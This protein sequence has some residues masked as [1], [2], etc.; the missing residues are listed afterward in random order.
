M[1]KKLPFITGF[2]RISLDNLALVGGKNASLGEMIQSL[3]QSD[4]SVPEGFAITTAAFQYFLDRNDLRQKIADILSE[5]DKSDID[6]FKAS[7]EHIR[8][9][10]LSAF[11]PEEIAREIE[12]AY[13]ALIAISGNAAVAVRSSATAEDLPGLSFAGQHDS[14]LFIENVD[15]LLSACKRCYASLYTDRALSYR[16]D[17]G[18]DHL[19][20]ALSIGVQ[21][22]VQADNA[23]SGVMFTLDPESGSRQSVLVSG[24]YGIGETI[25]QGQVEPDEFYVHKATFAEGFESVHRH[26]LGKKHLKMIRNADTSSASTE[27]V[28]V[29][30]EDQQAF[31]LRDADIIELARAAMAIE[32]HYSKRYGQYTPMDIEW[33]Q[34]DRNKRLYI[35]QARPETVHALD[36]QSRIIN[37]RLDGTGDLLAIGRAVGRKIASG[38]A[39]HVSDQEKLGDFRAGDILVTATTSPDWEPIM[40]KA[41][42]IITDHGGRTCHSAIVA[43]ELGIPAVV[44]TGNATQ[45]VRNGTMATVSCAEGETGKVYEGDIPYQVTRTDIGE[46]PRPTTKIMLNMADPDQAFQKGL[47]PGDGV[48]LARIEFIIANIIGAHPMALLHPDRVNDQSV[49]SALQTLTG[50]HRSGTDYFVQQLA[51]GIATIA[52]GFHPRP[53]IV[54]ASDFKSNEYRALLGGKDFETHE[55]NPMIGFRGAARYIHPDY[56]EAFSLECAA[57]KHAR[58]TMGFRNIKLMIP[59]CR[60]LQEAESVLEALADNGL[61]RGE[62]GLEIYM[63]CE[64]PGNV[65]S[66]DAFARHFDGFSIGSNDLTQLVL[67]I[68]RD[69]SRLAS[70]FTEHDPAVLKAITMAVEGAHR[71]SLP[72][73]LCGQAPSDYPDFAR[74]LVELGIDTISVTPDSFLETLKVAHEAESAINLEPRAK[75]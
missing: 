15:Q 57:L 70:T 5:L 10:I 46:L 59:F 67:G 42:A 8:Q 73:G 27:T 30:L 14:F 63:M 36:D 7:G 12:E 52:A 37:Y 6:A 64:I 48:G 62:Q 33:A 9:A 29:P 41:A 16:I 19:S 38:I 45:I 66:I 3:P 32:K 17:Q 13:N 20:V 65:L 51:E 11:L 54:R 25:V 72:V 49:R 18:V 24:V 1:N 22:M 28:P 2:D 23:C 74:F 26:K 56:A 31:C 53:V 43:R 34:D 4:I 55:E 71:N 69:S 60:T 68:D 50:H 44:G 39:Q 40:K 47:L 61:I 35:L 58:D 21:R 75:A